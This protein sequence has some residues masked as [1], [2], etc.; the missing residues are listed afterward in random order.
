MKHT[1]LIITALMLVVGCSSDPIWSWTIG[2]GDL[3]KLIGWGVAA[4]ILIWLGSEGNKLRE[5]NLL[6]RGYEKQ[7]S[8]KDRMR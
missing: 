6:K 3:F 5:K 8:N 7:S 1:L 4:I 2:G